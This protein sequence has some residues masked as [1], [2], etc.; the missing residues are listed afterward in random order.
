MEHSRI[1]RGLDTRAVL[2]IVALLG[3]SAFF[4]NKAITAHLITA[5]AALFLLGVGR[6]K[7]C[8]VYSVGYAALAVVMLYIENI[9]NATVMLMLISI[10]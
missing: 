9:Q 6:Y 3:I 2:F 7:Q 8:L 4:M 10:S 1:K 5:F